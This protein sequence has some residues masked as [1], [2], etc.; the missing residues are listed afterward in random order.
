MKGSLMIAGL[1]PGSDSL[2]TPEVT[3]ALANAT[4][5]VG[6]IPYVARIPER[7]GLTLHAS[8]NRVEVIRARQALELAANGKRVV[9][10]SS[11][12]PGVF[13]M[14]AAV[15][16]TLEKGPKE[17]LS[18]EIQVLP[19]ITAMLAAAAC[20]GA[21]LGHDF[22]FFFLSDNLKPWSLIERRLRLAAEADFVMAFYNPR[23]N[24]RP[25]GFERTLKILCNTCQDTRPVIFARAVS[26][27]EENI[28]VVTLPD[29]TPD[30]AD[31]RTVVI[32]G[33][34]Q[35][36]IIAHKISPIVYTPRSAPI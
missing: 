2:V 15:F 18:L 8:D 36:R 7:S 29:A 25:K 28:R 3:M 26:T 22:F 24:S 13:A 20:V 32:I 12:D 34:S 17:W 27:P 23:S 19:G 6:Y 33:S 1:G 30:M 10:V 11:G 35:T 16:E 5:I 9:V 31:M 14:A 4:D 21:P